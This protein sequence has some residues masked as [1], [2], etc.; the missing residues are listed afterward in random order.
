M[1]YMRNNSL[2]KNGIYKSYIPYTSYKPKIYYP[3][4]NKNFRSKKMRRKEILGSPKSYR[5]PILR[6][7]DSICLSPIKVLTRSLSSSS[8]ISSN[9]YNIFSN[10]YNTLS[11]ISKSSFN[12][13]FTNNP[14]LRSIIQP[15]ISYRIYSQNSR[16]N[17]ANIIYKVNSAN[18]FR[19][20][21][22]VSRLPN[23]Y[24]SITMTKPNSISYN[25]EYP[26][27]AP[28]NYAN[29]NNISYSQVSNY[30]P[31]QIII[32]KKENPIKNEN[33]IS[34]PRYTSNS[35]PILSTQKV[36]TYSNPQYA[37]YSTSQA[38][39]NLTPI[40][41]IKKVTINSNPQ[42]TTDSNPQISL[43]STP[44]LYTKQVTT[45]SKMQNANISPP[46]NYSY[47]IPILSTQQVT[48]NSKP[49][50]TTNST[51][52]ISTN[53]ILIYPT[54]QVTTNSNQQYATYSTP[55]ISP[56][57]TPILSTQKIITN[58]NPQY[59]TYTTL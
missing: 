15:T 37:T 39:S 9:N 30:R 6:L 49:Q 19:N 53:S 34:S 35:I 14:N 11:N 31:V 24:H 33:Y 54:Q 29:T 21:V 47:F 56:N 52:Q 22:K 32:S 27:V 5:Y 18:N 44:I 50:Y 17:N 41:S 8:I 42:Y 3:R 40:L 51:P 23:Q 45:Y 59:T 58:S 25:K 13:N 4:K 2:S 46:Q 28:I 10:N 36:S 57:T 26:R 55:Q 20:N 43:N 38:S 7:S 16:P 48:T 12:S 1:D